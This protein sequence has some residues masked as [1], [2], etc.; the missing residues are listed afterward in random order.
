MNDS[1][2]LDRIID[3]RGNGVVIRKMEGSWK[4]G[5]TLRLT[6]F[7]QSD[8][9]LVEFFVPDRATYLEVLAADD[10]RTLLQ[11]LEESKR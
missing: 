8:S 1:G 6:V 4:H 9:V 11:W 7:P 5:P 3:D 10:L 2:A